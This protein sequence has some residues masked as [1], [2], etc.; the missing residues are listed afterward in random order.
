VPL[1]SAETVKYELTVSA[2]K[3]D[4]KNEPVRVPL[5]VPGTGDKVTLLDGKGKPFAPAKLETPGIVTGA[6]KAEAKKRRED[7][8]FVLPALKAGETLKLTAAVELREAA[9]AAGEAA[10][11]RRHPVFW[12]ASSVAAGQSEARRVQQGGAREDVS[13]PS[14]R[15]TTRRASSC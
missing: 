9:D 4:R 8:V 6:I 14:I 3:H 2:G 7:L 15:S 12:Q 11:Q 1:A 5:Q 13:S 10:E